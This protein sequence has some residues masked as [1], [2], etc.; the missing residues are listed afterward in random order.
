MADA[1]RDNNYVTTMMG[2]SL[3]DL[4][5]PARVVIDSGRLMTTGIVTNQALQPG[6]DYD[7]YDLDE[8]SA[9]V[10]THTYRLGG[11]SGTVVQT[12]VITFTDASKGTIATV[13]YT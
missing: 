5:T 11:V 12:V 13:E 4:T 8:T 10:E 3:S 2:V 6:V 9:T 1:K 7:Y